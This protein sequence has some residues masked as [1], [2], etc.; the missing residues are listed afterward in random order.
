MNRKFLFALI[1]VS[2]GALGLVGLGCEM[3]CNSSQGSGSLLITEP[4]SKESQK[5]T[6]S[7][8]VECI[9]SYSDAADAV[10]KVS[11]KLEYQ[12]HAPWNRND[13]EKPQRVAIHGE[14]GDVLKVYDT[15]CSQNQNVA[16]FNGTYTPQPKSLGA[17]GTFT[18]RVVDNGEP[19][20]SP[21]DTFEMQ[22]CNGVF[23]KYYVKGTL[24]GGNLKTL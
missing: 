20:P 4:V 14:V 5:A 17:G 8:R 16:I 9:G 11:G 22:L 10:R 18:V 19:G 23:D 6:F 7:Y 12:D 2:I 3:C 1:A 13:G 24:A 15:W 21:E